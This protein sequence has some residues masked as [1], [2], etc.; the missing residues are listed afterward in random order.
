M[1]LL[2]L[3]TPL[4]ICD[5]LKAISY[6]LTIFIIISG[7]ANLQLVR[8]LQLVLKLMVVV[9]TRGC[10]RCQLLLRVSKAWMIRTML[11]FLKRM[12]VQRQS[13]QKSAYSMSL[14]IVHQLIN[15][16]QYNCNHDCLITP[17]LSILCVII[18]SRNHI[19][20]F[21]CCYFTSSLVSSF[22]ISISTSNC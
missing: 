21:F 3:T 6:M 13:D 9:Y 4:Y 2:H 14:S 22:S 10:Y 17:F 5:S 15:L 19:I 20:I 18:A 12:T 16:F 7:S 11:R 1:D 8:P